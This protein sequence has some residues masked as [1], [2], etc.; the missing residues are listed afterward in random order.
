VR[1]RSLEQIETLARRL[2]GQLT[3]TVHGTDE[4]LAT[5][6]DLLAMLATKAGRLIVNGWP[7]GVEV[8]HA[9]QHGGPWPATSDSRFTSVGS[10]DLERFIRPDCYQDEPQTLLPDAL[11]DGNPLGIMRLVE[12][13]ASHH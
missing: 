7:T 10:A 11:K 5:A 4:D 12:G 8:C 9:M 3:A 6:H 1:C 2:D 13:F